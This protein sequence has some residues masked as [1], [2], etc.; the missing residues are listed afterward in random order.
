[1]SRIVLFL[2]ALLLAACT[3]TSS[4]SGGGIPL[5]G[6]RWVLLPFVNHTDTPQAAFAAEA[7]VDHLVRA[8]GQAALERYPVTLSKDTLFE[9]AE[10]KVV[11]EAMA[12]AKQQGARYA[13]GGSV[14]EWRYKVG[15]DGEPAVGVTLELIDLTTGAV[16][17]SAAGAKSGW[18]RE[19][20]SAVAQK[21]LADLLTTLPAPSTSK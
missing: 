14:Q 20:L 8:R 10:R 4:M 7:I 3:T 19:A 1:M 9:P 15:I 6:G 17:W 18:S 21:L 16:V 5:A 11:E 13:L 2:T 12:W